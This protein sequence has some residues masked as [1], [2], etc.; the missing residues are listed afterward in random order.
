MRESS[1]EGKGDDCG[2]QREVL[3][4]LKKCSLKEVR[5]ALD[6]DD[7]VTCGEGNT[8]NKASRNW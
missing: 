1:S 6:L 8:L 5:C 3:R 2:V 7:V 4:T